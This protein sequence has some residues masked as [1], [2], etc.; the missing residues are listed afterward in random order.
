MESETLL[1]PL[2][3]DSNIIV[4]AQLSPHERLSSP[5]DTIF[6]S[7]NPLWWS[8]NV[9]KECYGESESSGICGKRKY[10]TLR[11][12]KK[13][14]AA[15][16]RGKLEETLNQTSRLA[17]LIR[18]LLDKTNGDTELLRTI[19][20][21][22]QNHLISTYSTK[23]RDIENRLDC[24]CRKE[25]HNDIRF[26]I[27]NLLREQRIELDK[28]DIEIWLDVHDLCITKNISDLVFISDDWKHVISAA[29]IICSCTNICKI[30]PPK[31]YC[32]Q[33]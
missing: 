28:D 15:I 17:P 16:E 26:R 12:F 30:I 2:F 24:H 22:E 32:T 25:Y 6:S 20:I 3:L 4:G 1:P 27:I 7:D 9:K 11:E 31:D 10:E 33:H 18:K 29:N 14:R 13:L 19:L 8:E 23:K 5:A 21:K